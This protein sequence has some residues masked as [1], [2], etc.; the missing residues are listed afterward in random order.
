[1]ELAEERPR[2]AT[3]AAERALR[4]APRF[5]PAELVL[6]EALRG[7]GMER[8]ADRALA[9]ALDAIGE[10]NPG[11]AGCAALEA[12]MRRAQD[13]RRVDD[14]N[15]LAARLGRGDPHAESLVDRL[16]TRGDLGAAEA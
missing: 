1:L 8:D 11:P 9:R 3:D 16:R 7:R 12:A 5:W 6:M 14:E 15:R 13:R 4:A 10:R 2:E